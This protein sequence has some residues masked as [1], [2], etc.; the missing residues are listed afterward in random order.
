MP[1]DPERLAAELAADAEVLRSLRDNGDVA[2]AVRPVD[3]RF[4]GGTEEIN[5]LADEIEELGWTV[6]QMVEIDEDTLALDVRRDQTADDEA[7][8]ALTEDAL[9]IEEAFGVGYSGWGTVATAG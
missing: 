4:E 6:V 9:R 8:R 5:A 2:S 7:I 3:V 1:I